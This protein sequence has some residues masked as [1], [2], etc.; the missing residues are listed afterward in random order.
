MGKVV[1]LDVGGLEVKLLRGDRVV[2][3]ILEQGSFEPDT[4]LVWKTMCKPGGIALDIGAYN[5]LFAIIAAHCGC[6]SF[7]FEPMPFNHHRLL[8]NVALNNVRVVPSSSLVSDVVGMREITYNPKVKFTAGASIYRKE[9]RKIKV[10]SVT[11]DSLN[12]PV[13]AIK[14]D[15]ERAEDLVLRGAANTLQQYRPE[16]IVEVLR[17]DREQGIMDLLPGYK[18]VERLDERNLVLVPR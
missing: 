9:G 10:P 16:L 1:T 15:V 11:V 8:Q 13:T 6:Q 17:P 18:I 4:L 2:N 5:G 14:I 3:K 12:L 7:A